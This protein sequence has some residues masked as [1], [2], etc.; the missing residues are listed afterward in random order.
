MELKLKVCDVDGCEAMCCHDGVYL[1]GQEE[2]LLKQ[3]VGSV[4]EIRALLPEVFIVDGYWNG[5]LLGRK[6]ATRPHVYRNP[7][8]PS[9]FPRT[10]CVFADAAGLCE[11]E[12]LGRRRGKHP[13]RYK[14]FTCWM[15][16]LEE[17]A[18]K[19]VPP[20]ALATDDPY[21]TADYP[22]FVSVVGCGRHDPEGR[23]WREA[24]AREL[25]YFERQESLPEIGSPPGEED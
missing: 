14:P 2:A 11:L 17:D 13:W 22:G 16:P 23:P 1:S 10:R 9:H 19:A 4:P 8:Y 5:E 6:T 18:G 15:F 25:R 20:S 7:D 24:L 3:L 12:K 21:R